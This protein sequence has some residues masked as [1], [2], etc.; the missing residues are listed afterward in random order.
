MMTGRFPTS[1]ID[2]IDGD[3]LNNKW[4]NIREADS[5]LNKCNRGVRSD[6]KSGIKGVTK[7]QNNKW[8]A[9]IKV[10]GEVNR[11]GIFETKEAAYASY[12]AAATQFFGEF[13]RLS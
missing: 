3:G 12:C 6:S 5:F 11:L 1:E 4:A 7:K 10:H 2:H 9:Q 8:S 13:A